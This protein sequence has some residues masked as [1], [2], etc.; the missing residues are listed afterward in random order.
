MA[1]WLYSLSVVCRSDALPFEEF[2]AISKFF[3]PP[4]VN[5]TR[6]HNNIFL[7]NKLR[8]YDDI[9][10]PGKG[11]RCSKM[12]RKWISPGW[13]RSR[14]GLGAKRQV[15]NY[16]KLWEMGRVSQSEKLWRTKRKGKSKNSFLSATNTEVHTRPMSLF[17]SFLYESIAPFSFWHRMFRLFNTEPSRVW[18]RRFL[19]KLIS[20]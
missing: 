20:Q 3:H 16:D 17:S 1:R 11:R 13:F 8:R 5:E 14:I 4:D 15:R 2:P 6:S 10:M 18:V 19:H 9:W 12:A 7:L